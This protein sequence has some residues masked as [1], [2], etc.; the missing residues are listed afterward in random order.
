MSTPVEHLVS[1]I[2]AAEQRMKIER[3]KVFEAISL[4]GSITRHQGVHIP[5]T[6]LD[7]VLPETLHRVIPVLTRTGRLPYL[8]NST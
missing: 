4:L 6:I 5:E 8:G 7:G 2:D 1:E 3:Q